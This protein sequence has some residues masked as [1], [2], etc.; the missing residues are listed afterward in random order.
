MLVTPYKL[1]FTFGGLLIPETREIARSFLQ[2]KDW[3][4]VGELVMEKN[5][6]SK[7][8]SAS[9]FRYFREIRD[10]LNQAY[11]W[12]LNI[13]GGES[14]MEEIRL[15]ILVVTARYYRFI[16]DFLVEVVHPKV[17]SWDL[18]FTDYDYTSFVEGKMNGHEELVSKTEST[19]RKIEQVT[20]RILKEAGITTKREGEV[21][22][23]KPIV[24][25]WLRLKYEESNDRDALA[26][27]L[28]SN[29]ETGW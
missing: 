16:F 7:T 28:L 6:L 26:V 27:L 5:I 24:P 22:I 9:R 15:V 20:F 1:S 13:I 19:L 10:R 21:C 29:R 3:T 2:E 12:E 23:N 14:R 25:E 8:R 11:D 17:F 4:K 18:V